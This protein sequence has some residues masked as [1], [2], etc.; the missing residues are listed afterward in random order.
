MNKKEYSKLVKKVTAIK[1]PKLKSSALDLAAAAYSASVDLAT[2]VKFYGTKDKPTKRTA[3]LPTKTALAIFKYQDAIRASGVYASSAVDV[4]IA[5]DAAEAA[6]A[7]KP[8][9]K[10]PVAKKAAVKAVVK[11][12]PVEAK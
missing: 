6:S 4:L 3:A 7:K 2:A 11:E 5:A 8:V 1:C 10:K 12:Q 9:A